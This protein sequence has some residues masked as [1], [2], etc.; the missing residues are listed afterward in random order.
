MNVKEFSIW[1][2]CFLF[3]HSKLNNVLIFRSFKVPNSLN[4]KGIHL[5]EFVTLNSCTALEKGKNKE[6]SMT[7]LSHS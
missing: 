6:S 3:K 4:S 7:C 5:I 2:E 1:C